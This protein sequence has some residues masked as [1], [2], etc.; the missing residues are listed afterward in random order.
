MKKN[1]VLILALLLIFPGTCL[2]TDEPA[3]VMLIGA[4]H[5]G[6]PGKDVVK[7]SDFDVFD[8]TS[9]QFLQAFAQRLATFQP[10]QVLLEYNPENEELINQRYRDYLARKY[11]LGNNEIYQMGFRIAKAAG[12]EAVQSFDHRDFH[13][14]P[15]QMFKYAEQHNSPEMTS[16]ND[17][18]AL[19]TEEDEKAR[20]NMSLRELLMR[21]NDPVQDRMN[22][23]LYLATN[24]IGAGDGYAGA[25][26]TASWWQ[27]NFRM[28]ANI[29]RVAKPGERIIVIGGSGHTAILKQL[30]ATDQRLVGVAVDGYF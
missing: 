3:Q 30:L 19:H 6:N 10:T 18:I 20:A 27:R 9:Q 12:L 29:Q 25:D 15:Q 17:A 5:F 22:M 8:E 16:F 11:E 4:F 21:S 7:V 1:V 26:A 2:P 14:Q 28:Y 23:D 24:S 13:W